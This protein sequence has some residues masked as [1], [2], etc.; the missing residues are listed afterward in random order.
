MDTVVF[1]L[2]GTLLPLWQHEFIDRYF[3]TLVDAFSHRYDREM[4]KAA[5]WKGTMAMIHNDGSATN[6]TVFWDE[7]SRYMGKDMRQDQS[8]IDGYYSGSFLSVKNVVHPSPLP[9]KIVALLKK[10]GYKIALATNPTFPRIATVTRM[11]WVGL[12]PDDFLLITTYEKSRFCKPNPNYYM[13]VLHAIG[14]TPEESIMVGNDVSDDMSALATG[15]SGFL[16]TDFLVN[17][18]HLDASPYPQGSLKDFYEMA[19]S[20][21]ELDLVSMKMQ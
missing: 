19:E 18:K 16:I 17:T 4:F 14:S 9:A 3:H 10:K 6:E 13:D 15:M 12:Q 5:V 8:V 21:P 7:M 11:G 1:D 2:D 20:L